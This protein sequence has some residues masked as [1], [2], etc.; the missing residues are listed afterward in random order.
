MGEVHSEVEDG[1]L[2]QYLRFDV[3]KA[4]ENELIAS[5]Y[6]AGFSRDYDLLDCEV[7]KYVYVGAGL[8]ELK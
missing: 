1:K 7:V 2:V 8:E 3:V 4:R 5:A 6:E